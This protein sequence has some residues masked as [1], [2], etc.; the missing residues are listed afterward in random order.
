M[1]ASVPFTTTLRIAIRRRR[2]NEHL[3]ALW[4]G[5][6]GACGAAAA[7]P[8][9]SPV[10]RGHAAPEDPLMFVSDGCGRGPDRGPC[11][12]RRGSSAFEERPEL[13]GV[14]HHAFRSGH[15]LGQ[16]AERLKPWNSTSP[17]TSTL[18]WRLGLTPR[19]RAS[20]LLRPGVPARL[21][22]TLSSVLPGFARVS[23][24]VARVDGVDALNPTLVRVMR[25]GRTPGA[26]GPACGSARRRRWP[27]RS[28][29]GRRHASAVRH[30]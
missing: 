3:P 25:C 18:R 8:W 20:A 13:L 10:R 11:A 1:D 27:P 7:R 28:L 15:V 16:G 9:A 23:G 21:P 22:S 4:W 26:P 12:P 14:V 24:S 29:G 5:S 19:R 30:R 6:A 17:R 2:R